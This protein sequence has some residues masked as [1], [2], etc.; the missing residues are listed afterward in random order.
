MRILIY[1]L[2]DMY[3]RVAFSFIDSGWNLADIGTKDQPVQEKWIKAVTTNYF[4][5]GFCGRQMY[6]S[7]KS[8]LQKS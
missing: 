4:E 7:L 3:T 6:K 2:R 8:N 1:Y 5:I